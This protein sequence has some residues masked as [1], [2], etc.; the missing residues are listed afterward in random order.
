MIMPIIS[1]YVMKNLE[2]ET[3]ESECHENELFTVHN[4]SN[5]ARTDYLYSLTIKYGKAVMYP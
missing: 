2:K 5:S 1:S 3:K 4:K